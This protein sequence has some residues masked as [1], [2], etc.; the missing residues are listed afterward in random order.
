MVVFAGLSGWRVRV[1][2]ELSRDRVS[3]MVT[4]VKM[5]VASMGD[6]VIGTSLQGKYGRGHPGRACTSTVYAE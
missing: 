4:V 1:K 5:G 3:D 6:Y 2:V